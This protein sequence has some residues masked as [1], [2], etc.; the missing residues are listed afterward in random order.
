MKKILL[1]VTLATMLASCADNKVLPYYGEVKTYGLVDA[2]AVKLP[3]VRYE[4]SIGNVIW[5]AIFAPTVAVPIYMVGFSI[6]EPTGIDQVC[7]MKTFDE[8]EAGKLFREYE[9]TL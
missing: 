6:M 4:V 1:A 8:T 2:S 9:K 3:C 5:S 7:M